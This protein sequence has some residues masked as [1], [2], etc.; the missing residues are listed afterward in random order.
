MITKADKIR[1]LAAQQ[2]ST[3]EIAKRLG[4][5]YQQAYAALRRP[6]AAEIAAKRRIAADAAARVKI[7]AGVAAKAKDAAEAATKAKNAAPT[8]PYLRSNQLIKM[9]FDQTACWLKDNAGGLVLNGKVRRGPGMYAFVNK[10]TVLYFGVA[11]IDVATQFK[12]YERPRDTQKINRRIKTLLLEALADVSK[13]DIYTITPPDFD[14]NSFSSNSA[15]GIHH[16]LLEK[17]YVDWNT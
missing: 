12:C 5:R 1:A 17:Y 10:N 2:V 9:G 13:I 16:S 14:W 7:A 15:I 6:S 4:I 11:T 3:V 8:K